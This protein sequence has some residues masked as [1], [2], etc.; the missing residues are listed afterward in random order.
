[1]NSKWTMRYGALVC[2]VAGLVGCSGAGGADNPAA[3]AAPAAAATKQYLTVSI[4][5]KPCPIDPDTPATGNT[6]VMAVTQDAD[7][8]TVFTLGI[9]DQTHDYK[10]LFWVTTA[11]LAPGTYEAYGCGFDAVCGKDN[12]STSDAGIAPFAPD[13]QQV[14]TDGKRAYKYPALGLVPLTLTIEKIEDAVVDG[15]GP[16][17][18][19]KGRFKGDLARLDRVDHKVSVV[20]PLKHVE[21][22]FDLY[23]STH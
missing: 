16:T 20:G 13:V 9:G 8:N 6:V 18:R 17:K 2:V 11:E 19:I 22:E 10:L 12:T 23:A 3:P 14:M 15:I 21:G 1:V 4:D 7:K 5:G